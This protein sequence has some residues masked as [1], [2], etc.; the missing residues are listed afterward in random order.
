MLIICAAAVLAASLQVFPDTEAIV[1][2]QRDADGYAFLHRRIERQQPPLEVTSDIAAI[3]RSIDAMAAAMRAARAGA[4]EGDL[5]APAV[6][7]LFRD[8]IVRAMREHQLTVADL[9]PDDGPPAAA[10]AVNGEMPWRLSKA[11]PACVLE[12]LPA[13]PAELQYRFVGADLL[14]VDV[15][16]SLIVDVF[17]GAALPLDTIR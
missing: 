2:F 16:A 14:L 8:R 13:L 6:Q 11:T 12:A 7:P 5:F 17:H 3:K 15:H 10:L 4:R 9:E 1:T